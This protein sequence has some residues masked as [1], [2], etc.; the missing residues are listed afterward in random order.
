MNKVGL[1]TIVPTYGP[2]PYLAETLRS[3]ERQTCLPREVCVVDDGS[4][5]PTVLPE[6]SLPI[7]I[8]RIAHGGISAA[9]NAGIRST[10]APLIHVCD[11]DDLLEPRFYESVVERFEAN[12]ILDIVHTAY[13]IIDAEGAPVLGAV[14]LPPPNYMNRG[15]AVRD[16]LQGNRLGSVAT[17]FK[18]S[19]FEM[20]GGFR[21]FQ[22]V[23]DWDFWLRA[24][25]SGRCFSFLPEVLAQ[26]RV[27]PA[28][29]SGSDAGLLLVQ[30]AVDMLRS[31]DLPP[32]AHLV[33]ARRVAGFRLELAGS[34]RRINRRTLHHLARALPIRPRGAFA[35][36]RSLRQSSAGSS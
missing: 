16:L 3:I 34:E 15:E 33:R 24:A 26:H 1:A 32:S 9:R 13:S 5:P 4:E 22:T 11:H 36:L 17:V 29:Q 10:S 25:E 35:T 14:P 21:S 20:L 27:H 7:R 23:Q 2:A 6:T 30:E 31:L 28:Q 19:V 8:E 18:R 12:S